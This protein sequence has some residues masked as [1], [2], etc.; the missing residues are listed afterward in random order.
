MP[1]KKKR[2]IKTTVRM[3]I[4]RAGGPLALSNRTYEIAESMGGKVKGIPEPTVWDW[5]F[6]RCIPEKHWWMVRQVCKVGLEVLHEAN[7][8][9]RGRRPKPRAEA[10]SEAAA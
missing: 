3:I 7:E 5:V 1:Y 9:G 6:R 10:R 8:E 2:K 4:D